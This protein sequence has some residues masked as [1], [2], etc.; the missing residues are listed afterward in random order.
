MLVIQFGT[1]CGPASS[2]T[3][4]VG[5]IW[6]VGLSLTGAMVMVAVLSFVPPLPS[7]AR[8][9]KLSVPL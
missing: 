3:V 4:C 2:S 1:F 5:P 9:T 8:K 6:K 7:S